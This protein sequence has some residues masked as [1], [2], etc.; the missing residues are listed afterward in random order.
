MFA[1]SIPS[2]ISSEMILPCKPTN[3]HHSDPVAGGRPIMSRAKW[4]TSYLQKREI[5]I[6]T[7]ICHLLFGLG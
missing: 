5:L 7:V 3:A 6:Y 4:E 2:G 1:F